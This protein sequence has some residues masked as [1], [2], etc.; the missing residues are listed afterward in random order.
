MTP[1]LSIDHPQGEPVS[2]RVLVHHF[3]GAM[4]AGRAGSLA[5]D[6]LLMTLPN[7]RFATFDVDSLVDYRA[8]RPVMVFDKR[9]Y[10][11]I[12]MP[13]LVVDLVHDDDGTPFL[14]LHGPEPDY[15]WEEFA[16]VVNHLVQTLGVQ[17]A[18][19]MTGIPMATPH[20]RPT[21]ILHHGNH[22]ERLPE[23]PEFFGRV[24][25]P[26]TMSGF[27]ELRLGQA[28]L[29]S[30]GVSASVPHY[31]ARDGFP[32]GASALL[33]TVAEITGLALP[34]GD[35]EAA[36]AMNRAE[37]D[38]EAAAQAEVGAVVAALE[39]QYDSF[40]PDDGAAKAA[41]ALDLPSADEIGARLEAFLEA[42]DAAGPDDANLGSAGR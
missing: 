25:L 8:R 24:E 19:G 22:P 9:Q 12:S 28:G 38:A 2:P 26:G 3:D 35:L 36:A 11:S 40:V 34:V 39:A 7:Q 23:Q 30:R 6:Q 37:I 14:L 4:D 15:R 1:M 10:E 33:R 42:N 41:A 32:Q 16:A 5:V 27:L 20:T 21:Y 29:D 13:E 31:V 17:T 18:I